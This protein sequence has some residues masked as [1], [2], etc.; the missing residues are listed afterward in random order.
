MS[1]H[2]EQEFYIGTCV[3]KSKP[4]PLEG[5]VRRLISMQFNDKM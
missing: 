1:Y 5:D 3:R 4:R 2:D